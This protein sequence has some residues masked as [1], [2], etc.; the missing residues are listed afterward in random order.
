MNATVSSTTASTTA[1]DA[2][3]MD[4]ALALAARGVALASPNPMV[5]AVLVRDGK[6]IGEG[7][8]TYEGVLHAEIVALE[9]AVG[10]ARGATLYVNLEPC[11]HTG[12][13]GPC[14]KAL[15]GAGVAR[16]VA[17]MA[18]PNPAV[19]GRGF[20]ELRVAGIE[21]TTGLREAEARR[22]NE[23][24]A[25]WIVSKTPL[26]TLKSALT[27]DGQL[28]LPVAP[29]RARRKLQDRWITSEESRAEVQ[30]MRHGSDALL[31]GIGTVLADDPLLTD[32]TGLPR[33]RNLLRVVMDSDLRLPPRSKL[34]RSA[35][36]DVLVFTRAKE[37][38]PKAKALR[39]AGVEVVRLGGSRGAQPDL[40][41][42]IE[43]LGRRGILSVLLESGAT[44]NSAALAAEIVDK[45][46]VFFAP[47]IAGFAVPEVAGKK[48]GKARA[49]A[50]MRSAQQLRNVTMAQF[51]SDFAVEGYLR[52]V[53][54]TR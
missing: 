39:R 19:A 11:C 27:L 29:G 32:R 28:A 6:I 42:A 25:R 15:I 31:T 30:A 17:A 52:D 16:V 1:A 13:T 44:M 53:Y 50:G 23:P 14:T 22:L 12:R 38:S 36:G 8:H 45:M 20:K 51:G 35:D 21:V 40:R 9:S 2:A 43:E 10:T 41:A 24:F 3:F 47:K 54:R 18:D 46:R 48:L 33:R 37:D 26:V 34:V 4:R 5:G 7:F 49:A